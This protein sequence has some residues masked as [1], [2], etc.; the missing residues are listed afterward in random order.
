MS[1]ERRWFRVSQRDSRAPRVSQ[2]PESS[3]PRSPRVT[4]PPESAAPRSPRV[5]QP[6]TSARLPRAAEAQLSVGLA[7]AIGFVLGLCAAGIIYLLG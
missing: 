3:P 1:L 4:Q 7:L 6:P 2:P 5:T